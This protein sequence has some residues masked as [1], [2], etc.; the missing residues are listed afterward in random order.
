MQRYD[1]FFFFLGAVFFD[2]ALVE[3]VFA[4]VFTDD[5]LAAFFLT[6]AFFCAAGFAAGDFAADLDFVFASSPLKMRS[7]PETNFLDAPV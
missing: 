2:V 4:T 6:V 5:F 7:Q 1:F 3:A